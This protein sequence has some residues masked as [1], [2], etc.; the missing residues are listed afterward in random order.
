[1]AAQYAPTANSQPQTPNIQ[2]LNFGHVHHP[3]SSIQ[4]PVPAST[5]QQKRL[6]RSMLRKF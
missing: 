4:N 3:E 2:Q 6:P 1:L 5:I